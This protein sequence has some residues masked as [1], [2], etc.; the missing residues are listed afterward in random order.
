MVTDGDDVLGGTS[1]DSSRKVTLQWK[2]DAG[3][4]TT[5][6]AMATKEK[7]FINSLGMKFSPVPGTNV[8]FCI[9]EARY[10]DYATY[11]A[12][13]HVV[14]NAWEES[15]DKLTPIDRRGAIPVIY[16]NWDDSQNF[17]EWLSKKEGRTYRL[18]TDREWSFAVGIGEKENVHDGIT[19]AMLSGLIDEFPWG[20][21]WPPPTDAGNY[22]IDAR[23]GYHGIA[24]VMS[25]TANRFG[26]YDL[27]G[28]V[29]EW[30]EDWYD[31]S[32]NQRVLR[33]GAWSR[34]ERVNFLSSIRTARSP[35]VRE[36]VSY[37]FRVVLEL[38]KP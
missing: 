19:P 21:E 34:A 35:S 18:P 29:W 38:A 32:K 14:D 4:T 36:D 27:G 3:S 26:L 20:A 22:G 7:P 16:V 11:A 30:V 9:H 31:R 17:C 23:D 10:Q 12:N 1:L 28:N 6:L 37:G 5:D 25:Y 8:L 2:P 13:S 15:V 33:G 24:P